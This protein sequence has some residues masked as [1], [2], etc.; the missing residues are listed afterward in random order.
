MN[1]EGRLEKAMSEAGVEMP[2]HVAVVE[3]G[4]ARPS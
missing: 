4:L 3:A 2:E 1:D